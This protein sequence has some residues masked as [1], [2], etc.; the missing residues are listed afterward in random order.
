MEAFLPLQF[1]AVSFLLRLW[2]PVA[3]FHTQLPNSYFT[4]MF[5]WVL[6]V[7]KKSGEVWSSP[8]LGEKVGQSV[9]TECRYGKRFVSLTVR[10]LA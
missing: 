1:S 8:A 6:P 5:C 9:P 2:S 10:E 7:P 4:L 3:D